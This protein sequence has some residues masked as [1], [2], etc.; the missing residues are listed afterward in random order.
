ML[1]SLIKIACFTLMVWLMNGSVF[2]RTAML[3]DSMAP[4]LRAT[5]FSQDLVLVDKLSL[6]FRDP[7][8]GEV[9]HMRFKAPD[10]PEELFF[11][12]VGALPGERLEIRDGRLIINGTTID[13]PAPYHVLRY[14]N[15][16][17][18]SAGTVL[19]V[20]SD[21]WFVLGDNSFDSYDSRYWGGLKKSD[22]LGLAAM[23]VWPPDRFGRIVAA[24]PDGNSN[25]K[26]HGTGK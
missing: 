14:T 26:P 1:K 2:G 12:R 10:K 21:A 18:A 23:I 25:E 22:M 17:H 5:L 4:A 3:S 24:N 7:E 9:V 13:S 11:K 8:R 20:A 15:E 16:G 6:K 19:E